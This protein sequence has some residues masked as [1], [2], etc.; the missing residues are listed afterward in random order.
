MLHIWKASGEELAAVKLEDFREVRDLKRHLQGL[1]GLPRFR[2][3]LVS[4]SLGILE[5][6]DT[7]DSPMDLQ[8]VLLDFA[9]ASQEQVDSVISAAK[10]GHVTLGLRF[11]LFLSCRCKKRGVFEAAA[12]VVL[13]APDPE[14]PNL[15]P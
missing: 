13:I 15:K 2:Q 12:E 6:D 9:S 1:C 5:D 10:A 8:L 14:T 11:V 4:K 3:R 7:L